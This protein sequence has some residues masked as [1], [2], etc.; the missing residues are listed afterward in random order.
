MAPRKKTNTDMPLL[1]LR[2]MMVFPHMVLNFD[3]G[4]AK[5]IA[6]VTEA[7]DRNQLIFLTAQK[8]ENVDDPEIDDLYS[9]GTV[10]RII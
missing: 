7:M 5:S 1:A 10:C 9:V 3:V 2:G 6:A 8:D 4:R